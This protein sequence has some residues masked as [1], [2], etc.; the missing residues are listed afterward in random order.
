MSI[1][2][3]QRIRLIFSLV[4]VELFKEIMKSGVLQ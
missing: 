2:K 4:T 3:N 1:H